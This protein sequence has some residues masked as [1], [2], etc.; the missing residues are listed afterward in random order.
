MALVV[1][2]EEALGAVS[3]LPTQEGRVTAP[4]GVMGGILRRAVVAAPPPGAVEADLAQQGKVESTELLDKE[5]RA[6]RL[7]RW[8][9]VMRRL[10]AHHPL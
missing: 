1:A 4:K 8:V 7:N 6:S 10:R 9:G 3:R 2:Q 5:D